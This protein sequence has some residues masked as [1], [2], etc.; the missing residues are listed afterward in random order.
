MNIY[1]S[2]L[3]LL[4]GS[5]SAKGFEER[6]EIGSMI[7]VARI[8]NSRADEQIFVRSRIT[9]SRYSIT[10]Y[11]KANSLAKYVKITFAPALLMEVKLSTIVLVPS[12]QPF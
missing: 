12:N 8:S 1:D 9:N 5:N 7:T 3:E 4:K 6:R 10:Y 2:V 11:N